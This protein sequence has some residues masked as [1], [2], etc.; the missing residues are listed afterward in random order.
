MEYKKFFRGPKILITLVLV[1][2]IVV[3]ILGIWGAFK[4]PRVRVFTENREYQMG[5]N[6]KLKI[7]N[8]LKDTICFSSCYSYYFEKKNGVWK[9][10]DYP[11]CQTADLVEKCLK[12]REIKGFELTLPATFDKG[13]YRLA[14]PVCVNCAVQ[15]PFEAEQWYYS[16]EFIL[17]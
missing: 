8:Y 11:A 1:I 6:L 10:V 14:I 2:L 12:P 3:V 15:E 9:G 5:N 4:L 16:N 7:K 13:T 17:K